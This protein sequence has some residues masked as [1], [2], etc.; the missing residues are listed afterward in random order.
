MKLSSTKQHHSYYYKVILNQKRTIFSEKIRKYV[1][2]D[3]CRLKAVK[4][5]KSTSQAN[6]ENKH[7][8]L[9][10]VS[11]LSNEVLLLE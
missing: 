1:E 8:N 6:C 10:V 5:V 9:D 7:Y 2:L 3:Y 4:S 11:G